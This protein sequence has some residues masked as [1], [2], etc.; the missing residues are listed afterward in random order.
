[1]GMQR[2]SL[3]IRY[4]NTKKYRN[5]ELCRTEPTEIPE[6]E[7]RQET[8]YL[9]HKNGSSLINTFFHVLLRYK[10]WSILPNYRSGGTNGNAK[11]QP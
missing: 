7:A 6:T 11:N 3:D 10:G 5:A 8:Q 2:T 1:M 4:I 9:I